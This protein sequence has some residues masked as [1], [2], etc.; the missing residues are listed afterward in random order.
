MLYTYG[1]TLSVFEKSPFQTSEAQ[2]FFLFLSG[3]DTSLPPSA[4]VQ[5]VEA[6]C[7]RPS[8]THAAP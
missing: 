6:R 7:I 1:Q 4:L 2:F 3:P 5:T 8:N